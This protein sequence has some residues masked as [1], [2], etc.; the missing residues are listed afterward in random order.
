M[1]TQTI[2]FSPQQALCAPLQLSCPPPLGQWPAVSN[3]TSDISLGTY[4]LLPPAHCGCQERAFLAHQSLSI[5]GGVQTGL[6][7]QLSGNHQVGLSLPFADLVQ[8]L[9]VVR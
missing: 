1:L 4:S 9:R 6:D 3:R 2:I 5:T 7:Q 8:K